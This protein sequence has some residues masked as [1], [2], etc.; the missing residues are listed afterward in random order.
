MKN[1]VV[2][3]FETSDDINSGI[4]MEIFNRESFVIDKELRNALLLFCNSRPNL[5]ANLRNDCTDSILLQTLQKLGNENPDLWYDIYK[6][7]KTHKDLSSGRDGNR[8]S[9]SFL[10]TTLKNN[11]DVEEAISH[12]REVLAS[13]VTYF[14]FRSSLEE[15]ITNNNQF[16]QLLSAPKKRALPLS[17]GPKKKKAPGRLNYFLNASF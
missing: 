1:E 3:P 17:G 7:F 10:A 15:V 4:C 2:V 6:L 5:V 16:K 12:I 9:N 13:M 11:L 8:G 14:S